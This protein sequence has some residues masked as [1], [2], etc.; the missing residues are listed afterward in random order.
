MKKHAYL[1]GIIVIS[2]L[3]VLGI[4][5]SPRLFHTHDGFVHLSRMAAYYDALIHGQILPRWANNLNYGYG[6]PLFNFIYHT[7]YLLSVAGIAVGLSLSTTFKLVCAASFILSGILMF[8]WAK[9]F[10]K[11]EKNAFVVSLFY[12]FSPFRLV[13]LLVRGSFGELY[14]YALLPLVLY[15]IQKINEKCTIP[16]FI[17]LSVST[18]LLVISHNSISLVFFGICFLY[19]LILVKNTK[20]RILIISGLTTGLLLSAF[21]WIPALA[22]HKYTYGN[23]FMK[24]MYKS[25]FP[26]LVNFFIP[27]FFNWES[28]QTGGVS[29]QI[30]LF[31]S[32]ALIVSVISLYKKN[33]VQ[34]KKIFIFSLIL[35]AISLFLMQPVSSFLWKKIS[36][37]R[38][39]QFPWRLLSVISF[40]T[41]VLSPLLLSKRKTFIGILSFLTVFSTIHY[42]YPPLGFDPLTDEST[43]WNYPLNTTYFGETDVIWSEGPAK[44]YPE[45]RIETIEGVASIHNYQKNGHNHSFTVE[46]SHSAK[47]VANIQYFPGWKVYVDNTK[48]PIEFQD[49]LYRGLITFPIQSGVHKVEVLFRQSI[50]QM[51]SNIISVITGSFLLLISV[52]SY[53]RKTGRN[54]HHS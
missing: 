3:P 20:T 29:V 26:P 45:D 34:H 19:G 4:L 32:I 14:T 8:M 42:W 11:D 30:G 52:V 15:T 18:A 13:E 47:L 43:Y 28:L 12:Q 31:H 41:A 39:F 48:T 6:L 1:T 53:F 7:P 9:S 51:A 40:G 24:D 21:Y 5:V 22:E 44:Q 10:F 54:K 23:L 27:N 49:Q 36:L 25:H 37:L 17:F 16:Y 38:Q 2:L 50:V 33:T 35:I 46:S